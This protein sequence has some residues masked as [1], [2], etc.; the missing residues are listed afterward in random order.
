MLDEIHRFEEDGGFRTVDILEVRDDLG[1][2]LEPIPDRVPTLLLRCNVV[3]PLLFFRQQFFVR[4]A[5]RCWR[6]T[7]STC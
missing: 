2:V 1:H 6:D 7:C 3:G 4:L 5:F